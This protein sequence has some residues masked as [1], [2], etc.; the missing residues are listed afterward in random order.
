M[1]KSPLCRPQCVILSS[2]HFT[3]CLSRQWGRAGK[4]TWGIFQKNSAVFEFTSPI[5]SLSSCVQDHTWMDFRKDVLLGWQPWS[6]FYD[7]RSHGAPHCPASWITNPQ[8]KWPASIWDSLIKKKGMF[9]GHLLVLNQP[10]SALFIIHIS[11]CTL[12]RQETPLEL[13]GATPQSSLHIS[14]NTMAPWFHSVVLSV[15]LGHCSLSFCTTHRMP[16]HG[17]TAVGLEEGLTYGLGGSMGTHL[18]ALSK[19]G[20]C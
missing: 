7:C 1:W 6:V 9:R 8:G 5:F 20:P 19:E 3:L 17:E 18:P 11:V 10:Q 13:Q 2:N 12:L 16:G 15:R 14:P 4:G